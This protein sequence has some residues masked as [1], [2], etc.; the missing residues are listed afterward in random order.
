MRMGASSLGLPLFLTALPGFG[1][2]GIEQRI[3]HVQE[4]GTHSAE[5]GTLVDG[6]GNDEIVEP[7]DGFSQA[8]VKL[9]KSAWVFVDVDSSVIERGHRLAYF[10]AIMLQYGE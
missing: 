3:L 4:I 1:E 10:V 8:Y 7:P 5:P 6:N 2:Q 9:L